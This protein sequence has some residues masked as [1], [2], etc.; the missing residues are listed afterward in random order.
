MS[1]KPLSVHEVAQLTG[2]TVRT[3]HYYDEIG[4]LK[5]TI[6]TDAKYRLYTKDDLSR[7]KPRTDSGLYDIAIS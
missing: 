7:S 5:P 4:F 1:D 6:V 2:I 3:L